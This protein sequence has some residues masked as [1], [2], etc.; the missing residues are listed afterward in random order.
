M[1][2]VDAFTA[3]GCR[4]NPAAVCLL[5]EWPTDAVLQTIADENNLSETAF[6][7]PRNGDYDLRW[8]TPV[9]EVDLCG[10]ATLG[11]A[12]VLAT[13]ISPERETFRFHTNSGP[14]EVMRADHRFT[15]DF[16]LLHAEP[17]RDREPVAAALGIEPLEVW[18][19]IDIM[20][21]LPDEPSV[22]S[23]EPDLRLV[24]SLDARG[25]IVTA[26]ASTSAP[27]DFVSR[28]FA[29]QFGIPE[30]PVTGSAHCLLAPYW[31]EQLRV[32]PL[33][34]RQVSARG[35][36]LSCEVRGDRVLLTGE[37]TP[38]LEGRIRIEE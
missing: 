32:N 19:E 16:P 9:A 13:Y 8:F 21:V 29:P 3:P 33:L 18:R 26:A 4:G 31:A 11:A 30:D 22:W 35:G 27:Y 24:A 14:L 38:Y 6:V 28:F 5:E 20:A 36:G 7:L 34:A 37:V 12:Y 10:H 2:Q 17:V 1:Y 15:M 25:L 23:L